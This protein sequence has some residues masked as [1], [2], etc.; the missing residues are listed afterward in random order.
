MSAGSVGWH[1]DKIIPINHFL[2]ATGIRSPSN[3][4]RANIFCSH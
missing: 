1:D 4:K 3:Q 2:K